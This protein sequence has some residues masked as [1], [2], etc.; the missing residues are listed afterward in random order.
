MPTFK[1]YYTVQLHDTDA[2]GILFFANQLKI[3]HNVYESMLTK[4]G[5]GFQD[6]FRKRDFFIPIVHAETDFYHPL[7]DGDTVEIILEI[8]KVGT[9]SFTL[10]YKLTIFDETVVGSA[11]TVHVTIDPESGKKIPLPGKFKEKLQE[12]AC[13]D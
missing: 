1:D 6:R 10:S 9:T 5:F 13:N 11:K 7:K 4:A 8:E 2:A 3:V 12:L